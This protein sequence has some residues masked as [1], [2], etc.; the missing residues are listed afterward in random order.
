MSSSQNTTTGAHVTVGTAVTFIHQSR[1]WSGTVVKKHRMSAHVVCDHT[2]GFRG[3]YA[4]LTVSSETTPQPMQRLTERHRASFHPGDRVQFA[5]YGT[6]VAGLLARLN[7]Q[8][9]QVIADDGR[10]Y[11]VSYA[12]LQQVEHHTAAATTRTAT[13]IDAIGHRARALLMHYQLSQWS[14]QVDNGRKRAGSFQYE[15]LVFSLSYE[16]AKHAPEEEIQDTLLHEIAHALVGKA[17][18][19]DEIWRTKAIAIGCS[20]CRCHNLRCTLP[21]YIVHCE[22]GCRLATAECR[23]RNVICTRCRGAL[24]YQTYTEERWQRTQA[25]VAKECATLHMQE[26]ETSEKC[27]KTLSTHCL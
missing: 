27:T 24:V 12:L 13:E 20:G 2:R 4:L 9:A 1:T 8:R 10:G 5:V 17:H 23:R 16:F 7:P 25:A 19:H 3:L 18:N 26:G 14:F 6:L 15:T 11:R 22:R 21:R